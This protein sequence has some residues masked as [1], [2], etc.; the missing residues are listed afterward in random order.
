MA[1]GRLPCHLP[2]CEGRLGN[3]WDMPSN[4]CFHIQAENSV[5]LGKNSCFDKVWFDLVWYAMVLGNP[6][7]MPINFCFCVQAESSLVIILYLWYG[8]VWYAMV[9]NNPQDMPIKFCFYIWA[10]N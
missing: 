6:C 5:F 1:K 9:L 2:K 8:L 3:P 10:E 7:D 4:F